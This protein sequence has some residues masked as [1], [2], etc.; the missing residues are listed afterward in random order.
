MSNPVEAWGVEGAEPDGSLVDAVTIGDVRDAAGRIAGI[1]ER[2]PVLGF[3]RLDDLAGARVFLKCENLQPIG[4]FKIRGAVNA[5]RRLGDGGRGVITYSSGNHAQAVAFAAAR[6]RVPAVIVMPDNAP[7]VKL[8]ATRRLL[9]QAP[10]SSEV[11][12]YDPGETSREALGRELAGERGLVLIPPYDH[13]DVI[14]GQGTAALELFEEAGSLDELYVCCGGG[15]L[16]S[17]SAVAAKAVC[18][19][20]RVIGVEPEVADDATRSFRTGRLCVVRNPPTIADGA[21]TPFLGRYTFPLV[22]AHV[23]DMMTVS[24]AEIARAAL[25][26]IDSLR[27]VVEPSG[28]LGVA[29]ALRWAGKGARVGVIVSGGNMDLEQIGGL[30]RLAGGSG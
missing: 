17:G 18:P 19:A 23:D 12:V 25:F 30:R 26:C 9:A 24:E 15:G 1:A 29:G 14:A 10:P 3:A 7:R 21:R 27:L 20:C 11:I 13:P 5:M 2:A 28:A 6:L 16:L 8:A 22:R 4:A